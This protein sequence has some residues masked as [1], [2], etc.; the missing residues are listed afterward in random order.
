MMVMG[1]E[2]HRIS[3]VSSMAAVRMEGARS[4]ERRRT[5]REIEWL[6]PA[7]V[8][9]PFIRSLKSSTVQWVSLGPLN[10]IRRIFSTSTNSADGFLIRCA[11]F[12]I[13]LAVGA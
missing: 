2:C 10:V 6:F 11:G 9:R 13:R 1:E 7:R 5:A 3:A 4:R 8:H 12:P